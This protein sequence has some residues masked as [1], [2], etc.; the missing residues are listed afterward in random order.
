MPRSEPQ[1]DL[2]G[3]PTAYDCRHRLPAL[4]AWMDDDQLKELTIWQESRLRPG[5]EYFDLDH[6]ERGPF[7]A[8]HGDGPPSDHTYVARSQATTRAWDQLVTWRRPIS[9]SQ[10]ESIELLDR[11]LGPGR[12]R[13]ATGEAHPLPP[14]G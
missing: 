1:D 12:E 7:V 3:R 5:E 8:T 13:T 9:E 14:P 4:A 2:R 6:P 10:G 11:N